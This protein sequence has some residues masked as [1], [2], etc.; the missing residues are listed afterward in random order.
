MI[1]DLKMQM[2]TKHRKILTYTTLDGFEVNALLITPEFKNEN[3]LFEKP[4][5]INVHG[6]LGNFLARGTP[7]ILPPA[8]LN[9]GISTL[10]INTRMG[11]LGQILGEGIFEKANLDIDESVKVLKKEGFKNIYVLGYSLGANLAVYYTTTAENSDIKGLILEG[12]SY[13]LPDSQKKRLEKNKSIP[14]YEDIY[15]RAKHVLGSNPHDDRNDQVFIVYRAWGETFNPVDVEIFT[16]R[17]WWFMRS[18][19][20]EFAKTSNYI[21]SVK[22]PVLFIHGEDDNIVDPWEPKELKK[23]LNE[24]GNNNISLTYIPDAKHDCMENPEGTVG[25]ITNWLSDQIKG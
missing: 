16:Y 4:V 9:E 14:Q 7:Q 20:A 24:S 18:P 2:I 25:A 17:T 11:F 21:S 1:E 23:I 6:V 19:E 15:K 10:S 22:I 12:C 8:L 13:S 5:I 3:E